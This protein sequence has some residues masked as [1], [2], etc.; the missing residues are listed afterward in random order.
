MTDDGKKTILELSSEI[1]TTNKIPKVDTPDSSS[2]GPK[3]DKK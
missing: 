2:S 1:P 3:V